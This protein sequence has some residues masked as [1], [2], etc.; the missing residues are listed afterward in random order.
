MSNTNS[1][2]AL[3][4]CLLVALFSCETP[5]SDT[6]P[7]KTSA[8]VAD[9]PAGELELNT[10]V[11]L[12]TD[13]DGADIYWTGNGSAPS[14]SKTK[15]TGPIAVTGDITIKAVALKEGL[16]DSGVFEAAYTVKRRALLPSAVPPG[17]SELKSGSR[18]TL[19]TPEPGASIYY[20]LDGTEPSANSALYTASSSFIFI[21]GNTV[22]KAVA[23]KEGVHN[24]LVLEALYTLGSVEMIGIQGRTITGS[25]SAGVFIEGRTVTLDSFKIAKHETTYELWHRVKT[26][27]GPRGYRFAQPGRAGTYGID[28]ALPTVGGDQPVV[29]ITWADAIAWC[30]ALSEYTGKEPVYYYRGMALRNSEDSEAVWM[31]AQMDR[32][33]NGYRLPT[34]AEW[35]LAARGGN[36]EDTVNWNYTYAGGDGVGV[37]AWYMMNTVHAVDIDGTHRTGTLFPNGA[38]LHDMSGNAGEWCWDWH[39]NTID[40]GAVTNPIGP[41]QGIERVIRGGYWAS[42]ENHVT[43]VSRSLGNKGSDGTG[44]RFVCP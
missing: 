37:V 15:Y 42:P 29:A 17:G 5:N 31:N 23:V 28:G 40:T 11:S 10:A 2:S 43:V 30:N 26:W 38:G 6:A 36:P 32:S 14:A 20:T 8:P 41:T 35:E 1:F 19:S 39:S 13:T 24:S 22:I 9:P 21:H 12:Y 16:L 3:F 25:G 4:A 7:G 44:F 27:S 18:V 33:K 34:E